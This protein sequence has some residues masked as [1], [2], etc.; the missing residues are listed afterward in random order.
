M[1]EAQNAAGPQTG[2]GPGGRPVIDPTANVLALVEA[3]VHRLDDL[4]EADSRRLT[5]LADMR[6][7][8]E[9][10]LSRLREK[11]ALAESRRIDAIRA[12]D[13]NAVA[14]ASAEARQQASVL[15]N[16]VTK[17]A[18]TLRSLVATTDAA[19]AA[20]LTAILQPLSD[21]VS[22]L[23][24]SQYQIAGKTTGIG[25]LWGWIIGAA[26]AA[27]ATASVIAALIK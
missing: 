23:E 16:E 13:V 9:N 27:A 3:A 6:A 17:S 1:S 12:V 26:G 19:R 24:K 2:P 21:R 14:I 15:A 7:L 20:S 5:E 4:R 22:L 25:A 18:E 8:H 10:Q 11:L